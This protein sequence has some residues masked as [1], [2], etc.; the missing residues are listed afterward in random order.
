M[1]REAIVKSLHFKSGKPGYFMHKVVVES[2]NLTRPSILSTCVRMHVPF[3]SNLLQYQGLCK[4]SIVIATASR[5]PR[6]NESHFFVP[7]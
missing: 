5:L 2:L 6:I 1:G 4:R 7:L 3:L